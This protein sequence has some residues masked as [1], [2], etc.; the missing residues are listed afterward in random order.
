MEAT[1]NN[2]LFIA[3]IP[4][5]EFGDPEF[6]LDITST[7][8]SSVVVSSSDPSILSFVDETATIHKA[9]EVIIRVQLEEC[10]R[11]IPFV[12]DR[13]KQSITFTDPGI[14]LDTEWEFELEAEST[15]GLPVS[16]NSQNL[17]IITIDG[18]TAEIIKS[19]S[20][21]ITA[22]QGGNEFYKP[23][24]PIRKQVVVKQDLD[25]RIGVY[26]NPVT[27]DVMKIYLPKSLGTVH[28]VVHD[29]Q[30]RLIMERDITAEREPYELDVSELSQ[31][32]YV[33][34]FNQEVIQFLKQ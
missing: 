7:D 25:A 2:E 19:G 4:P 11:E 26:P 22:I 10:I 14:H 17:S 13:A 8:P 6:E 34:K 16:F 12:I 28:V 20:T 5:K 31:G 23:S 29:L 1:G 30:G 9:G 27:G 33:I 32:M 18:S 21:F 3:S 15:S 24:I